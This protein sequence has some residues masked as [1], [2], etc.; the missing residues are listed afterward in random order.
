MF[1]KYKLKFQSIIFSILVFLPIL[2]EALNLGGMVTNSLQGEPLNADIELIDISKN[3]DP[4]TIK[5]KLADNQQLQELG[6]SAEPYHN[7]LQFNIHKAKD[8]KWYI[9]VKSSQLISSQFVNFL[10]NIDYPQG[11]IVR[12]Y[13]A[14]LKK[15]IYSFD[16]SDSSEFQNQF[17][18]FQLAKK[19]KMINKLL[20][21]REILMKP[22]LSNQY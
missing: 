21:L 8:S 4:R 1:K 6:L 5:V 17:N 3:F 14:I 2:T 7:D 11:K 18:N 9:R 16:E 20:D 22:G 19:L 10:L 15:S 13:M 12:E